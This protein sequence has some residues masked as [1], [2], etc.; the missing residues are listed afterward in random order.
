MVKGSA[1]LLY[2]TVEDTANRRDSG[3]GVDGALERLATYGSLAPGRPNH[4]QLDGLEGRWLKGHVDGMFVD[5][6]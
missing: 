6:G 2:V 5:A 3:R 4:D 1:R